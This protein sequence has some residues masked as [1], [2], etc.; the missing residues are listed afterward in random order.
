MVYYLQKRGILL[1]IILIMSHVTMAQI[2]VELFFG[3]QKIT[4]DVLFFQYFRDKENQR[5]KWLFFHRN[6]ASID[7]AMTTTSNLPQLG[8]TE[9][10]SYNHQKLKGIAPVAVVQLLNRGIFSKAG[11][12]YAV[13]Q[14]NYTLFSW[15]VCETTSRPSID[16][17]FLGRYTPQLGKKLRLFTQI[18]LLN[19]WATAPTIQPSFVQ[20][21]RLGLKVNTYQ[22]GIGSDFS[23]SN[24]SSFTSTNN[25]GGFIRHEF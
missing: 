11:I 10:I 22:W 4:F 24:N 23:S 14:K 1:G 7:Y 25:I 19:T 16:W 5:T 6:R 12:Q 13:V 21:I 9:A 8:F 15:L 3:H 17:F 20:R 18:E 2:P